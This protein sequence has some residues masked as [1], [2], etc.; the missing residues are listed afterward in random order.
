MSVELD[1]ADDAYVQFGDEESGY[2]D[3]L[4][5]EDD[6]D[7]D[8]VTFQVNTRTVGT[9]GSSD[10]F[11]SDEDI[12]ESMAEDNDG[13]TDNEFDGVT[14]YDEE[15]SD[16]DT[17]EFDTQSLNEYRSQLDVT[18]LV[19]PLQPTDY[20]VA[21]NGNGNFVVNDDDESELDDELDLATLDLTAPTLGDVTTWTAPADNADEDDNLTD[22]LDTVSESSEIAED[23]RAVIQIEASG[24]YGAMVDKEDDYDALDDGFDPQTIHQVNEIPGEGITVEVE[25][26]E[27]SGNQGTAQVDFENADSS[28][29]FVLAD[30]DSGELFIIV[31]TSS[32]S[33]FAGT[34]EAGDSLTASVEYETDDDN[35]YSF[36]SSV[37]DDQYN[38]FTAY[39][40]GADGTGDEAAYPYFSADST[41]STEG[42]FDLVERDATFD[43]VN[44]DSV[45]VEVTE[46]AEITGE[47]NVA[48]GSDASVRVRSA[49]GVS[50]SFVETTDANIT[51][52]GTFSAEFDFSGQSVDDTGTVNFR[53]EG[54]SIADSDMVLIEEVE[55]EDGEDGEDT[56]GEDGEDTDGEDGED[57]DGEDGSD[58]GEDGSDDGEDGSDDGEDGSDDGGD[59]ESEDG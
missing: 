25:A 23:D 55:E 1:D 49:D 31:D 38:E 26:E 37:D 52:D 21:V 27:G 51:E 46:D 41:E 14:F 54:S 19:R 5:V 2:V 30:N 15:V 24:L 28:D 42:T 43:N 8:E 39:E 17:N 22:V 7:D 10:S 33:A 13:N 34:V 40:G 57:T 9:D 53:V 58:D 44:N 18:A 20:P 29:V 12:V 11:Y 32:S 4:Y 35:R 6:D 48:P 36:Q 47:T 3:V 59:G 56:D 50:P 16:D 45:E